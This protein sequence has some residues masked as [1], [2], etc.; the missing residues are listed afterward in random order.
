VFRQGARPFQPL[1]DPP[2]KY[3]LT[4]QWPASSIEDYDDL[5]ELEDMLIENLTGEVDGHDAGSG[6]MNIFIRTDSPRTTFEDAKSI[7]G[8]TS[9]WPNVRIAYRDI[10]GAE[11]TIL[12]PKDL[13]SFDV[14]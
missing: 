11:Y 14:A 1:G 13:K 9:L 5:I 4:L 7:L 2:V 3:V 10:E 6:E 12:W 8:E